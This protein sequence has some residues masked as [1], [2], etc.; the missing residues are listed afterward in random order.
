VAGAHLAVAAQTIVVASDG[1]GPGTSLQ[2]LVLP[3]VSQ[4]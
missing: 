2:G 4:R 3:D 1:P